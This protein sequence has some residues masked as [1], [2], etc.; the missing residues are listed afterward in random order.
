M[1]GIPVDIYIVLLIYLMHHYPKSSPNYTVEYLMR[2]QR[3]TLDLVDEEEFS[4]TTQ[5]KRT[6]RRGTSSF[7]RYLLRKYFY[8]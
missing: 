8:R 2:W 4:S 3:Q 5:E 7:T 6:I 1:H